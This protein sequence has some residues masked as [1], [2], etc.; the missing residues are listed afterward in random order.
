M[1]AWNQAD[2]LLVVRLDA[3]GDML[4][5]GP[6]IRA[7]AE[8]RPSRQITVLTSPAGCPAAALLPGVSEILTYEAP[9]MKATSPRSNAQSDL[10]LIDGLRR[11]HFDGAVIFTVYS[12]SALPAALLCFLAE[13]PL[14]LA[15]CRE[16]PYQLL[17]DWAR[18]IEPEQGVRHEVR[19]LLDLVATIGCQTT[20]ERIRVH[21]PG[22]AG[23]RTRQM[24]DFLGIDDGTLWAVIHPGASASSRRYPPA[25]FAQ[26]CRELAIEHGMRLV[27]TGGKNEQPL[28]DEIRKAMNAPS[29]SLVGKLA[30][31]ELAALLSAAPLLI[32]NNTG[33][34]HLAA[35]VG[36]PVV[37]L[38]ALTNPQHTPWLA[39]SRVL[40]HDV[41]CRW[42]YK[43]I[44]PQE[45]QDCL[46][47]VPPAAVV[48]AALELL[49]EF[50]RRP[51][52]ANPARSMQS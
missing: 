8:S 43:S 3:L 51:T 23:L 31:P 10:D 44:C 42:C 21:L 11:E 16:N 22:E 18:E 27:F 9:W 38:Y 28:V 17:T 2:R 12:Q 34:V 13:I 15:Y 24:L 48:G 19:R 37:V 47:K 49:F 26:A 50:R 7:L 1:I 35:A 41:P 5:S 29:D 14:R 46:R 36:C 25:M 6:A 39:P 32:A 52:P 45:H 33:P 4:M 20:D 30:L 40:N